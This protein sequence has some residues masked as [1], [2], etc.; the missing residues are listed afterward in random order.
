M[1]SLV[2]FLRALG[3]LRTSSG[4]SSGREADR[5]PEG[6]APDDTPDVALGDG[7]PD[8]IEIEITDVL[9]LHSFPPRDVRDITLAWLDEV[10][11]R[12]FSEVRVVHGR[13]KGVQRRIVQSVLSKDPRVV[14]FCDAPAGRGGWGATE[15]RLAVQSEPTAEQSDAGCDTR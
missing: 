13:G 3:L 1:T 9:D 12:G 10:V 7:V 6:D 15:V 2:D 8:A 14:S 5:H 11:L 4:P